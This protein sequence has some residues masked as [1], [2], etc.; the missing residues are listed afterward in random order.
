MRLK[1]RF[2]GTMIVLHNIRTTI[3]IMKYQ[4]IEWP[5]N[6]LNTYRIS[7]HFLRTRHI[8]AFQMDIINSRYV[9][10]L[11]IHVLCS[12]LNW[13]TSTSTSFKYGI[14][15]DSCPTYWELIYTYI[16]KAHMAAITII[17]NR[18]EIWNVIISCSYGL[19]EL[20]SWALHNSGI[21]YKK[22]T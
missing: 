20:R 10:F 15:S 1:I 9:S 19:I 17:I 7:S 4:K 3:L 14:S 21:N 8:Y 11:P 16:L 13:Q 6:K 5:E 12:S 2:Y 22:I 18:I